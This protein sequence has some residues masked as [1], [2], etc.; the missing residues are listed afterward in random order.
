MVYFRIRNGYGYICR[1]VKVKGRWKE[2]TLESLGKIR[3][4]KEEELIKCVKEHGEKIELSP[5]EERE[6]LEE[7]NK[8]PPGTKETKID[9]NLE[10]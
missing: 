2:E 6:I 5:E 8:H 10:I 3:T 7:I 1:K 4:K 9:A